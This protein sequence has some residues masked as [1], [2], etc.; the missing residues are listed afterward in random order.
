MKVPRNGAKTFR[1]YLVTLPS[2]HTLRNFRL[3]YFQPTTSHHLKT[4]FFNQVQQLPFRHIVLPLSELILHQPT[5]A[6]LRRPVSNKFEIVSSSICLS[7]LWINSSYRYKIYFCTLA[8]PLYKY[9]FSITLQQP[10]FASCHF[11]PRFATFLP[12]LLWVF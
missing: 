2:A 4:C 12:Q 5:L 7:I 1:I 3:S 11:R 9:L 10:A 6:S 8:L